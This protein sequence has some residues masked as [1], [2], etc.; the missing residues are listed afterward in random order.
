[1]FDRCR[2]AAPRQCL[3]S[4]QLSAYG[5]NCIV[6]LVLVCTSLCSQSSGRGTVLFNCKVGGGGGKW[7]FNADV[8]WP[9]SL[10]RCSTNNDIYCDLEL[11]HRFMLESPFSKASMVLKFPF[12]TAG[13]GKATVVHSFRTFH[14]QEGSLVQYQTGKLFQ[15]RS[16]FWITDVKSLQKS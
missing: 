16:E 8:L 6:L 10:W 2:T 7:D 11:V 14:T 1:M 13:T 5:D 15:I 9:L 3:K 12:K 4:P